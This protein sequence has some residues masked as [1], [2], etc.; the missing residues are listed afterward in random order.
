MF[1]RIVYLNPEKRFGRIRANGDG[2]R[3]YYF[4]RFDVDPSLGF[5]NLLNERVDFDPRSTER[6]L[7]AVRVRPVSFEVRR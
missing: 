3:E 2:R 6:G 4:S 7:V 1:G 5:I